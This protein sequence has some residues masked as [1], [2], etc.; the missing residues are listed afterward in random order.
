M[1]PLILIA[2]NAVVIGF[3]VWLSR[4]KNLLSSFSDGKWWLTWFSIAI[5]TLMDELTSIFYV[6]AESY[7]IVGVSAFVFIILTSVLMR[8]LSNRMVEIAHILELNNIKGGGVYSFS[9]LVM[10][11]TTSFVAVASILVTY[12]LT[13]AISTVAAV[14][15][16]TS[17]LDLGDFFSYGLMYAIIW[18]VAVLNVIGIRENARFTY[19]IFVVAVLVLLTLLASAMIDPSAGQPD[20][21]KNGVASVWSGLT[22]GGFGNGIGFLIFGIA[23]VI[24]AYSG[25]ESV[26]QTAGLV[27]S[28]KSI[29]KAYFFLAVSVGIFTPL[30][31]LFVL[32][33]TDI[34]F[35]HHEKDLI[36]YFATV[37]N[38]QWFGITVGILASFTL[39]MAVNTSFVASSEL[40]ERVAHRYGFHWLIKTNRRESLYRIHVINAIFFSLIITIT[41]GSQST[42]AHMYAVGLLASFSINM[43]ALVWYRYQSGSEA[44]K[45]YFTSRTGTVV[46]FAILVSCF[47]YT[48]FHNVDGFMMWFITVLIFLVIGL[49]VA[50]KRAPEIVQFHKTDNPLDLTFQIAETDMP[51]FHI[52]FRRPKDK[53]EVDTAANVAYITLYSPRLA[54]HEK[55]G[56]NHYLFPL[57]GQGLVSVIHT[58]IRNLRY[59][60]P[61]KNIT[62]HL[63]WPTSSWI[64]RLSIGVMVLSLLRLPKAF[65]EYNFVIEYERG[66]LKTE[67]KS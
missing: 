4:K 25:I 11:P 55:L 54:T 6:P 57:Q 7:A 12:I 9:Y 14:N 20:Q 17:F 10:G 1:K 45:E 63:G 16:S 31:T 38:G 52:Y 22:G 60:F 2:L 39:I 40:L 46:I 36:T 15:N 37:L 47:V 21:M 61:D 48:A 51:D 56:P 64:D 41:A 3:F 26:I 27:K 43:G 62:F 44:I 13:A 53:S 19:G 34:Q 32:T 8:F 35:A 18:F 5:I 23:S 42:L 59:D 65:P 66:H 67:K 28:W 50:K 58:L 24:L 30:L 29:K 49:R 33:R